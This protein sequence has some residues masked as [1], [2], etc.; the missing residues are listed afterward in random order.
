MG[1]PDRSFFLSLVPRPECHRQGGHGLYPFFFGCLRTAL[2]LVWA[3]VVGASK[4]GESFGVTGFR[5][6]RLFPLC[7]V[8]LVSQSVH[9][10]WRVNTSRDRK[11]TEGRRGTSSFSGDFELRAEQTHT[12]EAPACTAQVGFPPFQRALLLEKGPL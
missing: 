3:W 8:V 6:H 12:W 2:V 9:R 10:Q 11:Q 5:S 1:P 7:L 4:G